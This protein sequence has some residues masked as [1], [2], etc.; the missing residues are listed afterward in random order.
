[1]KAN[2]TQNTDLASRPSVFVQSHTS[3]LHFTTINVGIKPMADTDTYECTTLSIVSTT[4]PSSNDIFRYLYER[5]LYPSVST[6]EVTELSSALHL[7][8]YDA[9]SAA[10]IAGRYTYAE[11]LACHR[12]ALL[13]DTEELSQLDTFASECKQMAKDV[14]ATHK[15]FDEYKE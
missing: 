12:K 14:F 5:G 6:E 1:M 13:G 10:L 4:L 3:A 8:T 9:L 2:L 15:E 7:D 11:E